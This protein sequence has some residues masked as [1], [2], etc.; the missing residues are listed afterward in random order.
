MSG[1]TVSSPST[2]AVQ[3]PLATESPALRAALTPRLSWW[4]AVKRASFRA[5]SSRMAPLSSGEPSLM[6]MHSQSVR[7]WF[8]M[9]SRQ[10]LRKGPER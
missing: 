1:S 7:V 8:L 2:K 4:M 6:Q 3:F 10:S 9:E 5:Y